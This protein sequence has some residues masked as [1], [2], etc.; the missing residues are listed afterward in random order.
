MT[1]FSARAQGEVWVCG[2]IMVSLRGTIQGFAS[3]HVFRSSTCKRLLACAKLKNDTDGFVFGVSP[4]TTIMQNSI[5]ALPVTH[6][7]GTLSYAVNFSS[8]HVQC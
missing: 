1:R 7:A 2:T 5:L 6:S 8:E 4:K 3:N